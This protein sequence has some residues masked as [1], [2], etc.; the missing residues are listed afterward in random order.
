MGVIHACLPLVVLNGPTASGK[1]SLAIEVAL[2][3]SRQG[4]RAEIV[5]C[6]SMLVYRGM[7]IGTA[8]PTRAELALVPHH[9]VDVCD[10][11]Q[12]ATVADF[13]TDARRVIAELRSRGVVPV[14][15]GGSALYVHAI[16]DDFSFPATDPEVRA[17]Y[18]ARL[19]E[20]GPEALHAEL[21]ALAPD[22]AAGMQ[23]GNGRR[24][25]R[26]LEVLEIEG[27][28]TPQL[29]EWTYA[30]DDVLQYGLEL[31]RAVM[32]ERINSRVD[33]MWADGLVAEVTALAE[34]GLREGFTASRA[35]GYRQVLMFLDGELNEEEA[36]QRTAS[37]T[38]RFAR[39][40]LSWFR[41]DP[42]IVW[43]EAGAP[44]NVGHIVADVLAAVRAG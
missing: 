40:Q 35:L 5:N 21:A 28:F 22:V 33:Q 34:D 42:R 24:T 32:D 38:R 26:A 36:R 12:A 43:L 7:D 44:D 18:E 17:R 4:L 6:D 41:R 8:K 37:G 39:K 23:A 25:V 1:S 20:I 9:L 15:V 30:V 16:L 31:D 27:G 14:M 2:E 13:Q 29:P 10:V 11:R 19:D 3:L